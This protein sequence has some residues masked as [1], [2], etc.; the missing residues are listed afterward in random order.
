[1]AKGVLVEQ[2]RGANLILPYATVMPE[3]M[4][5]IIAISHLQ[6]ARTTQGTHIDCGSANRFNRFD[7]FCII[8][9]SGTTAVSTVIPLEVPLLLIIRILITLALNCP[10]LTSP[11][12]R[13]LLLIQA[14]PF[15]RCPIKGGSDG[16]V[17][18]LRISSSNKPPPP[19]MFPLGD[20][21]QGHGARRRRPLTLLVEFPDASV[22]P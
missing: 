6:L 4:I 9:R 15:A 16:H 8:R 11:R 14:T 2:V 21:G 19:R 1:M 17:S 22:S 3:G 10:I 7:A 13:P 20:A 18:A 12:D 5:A